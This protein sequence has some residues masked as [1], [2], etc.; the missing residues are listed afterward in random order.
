MV[1]VWKGRITDRILSIFYLLGLSLI[2]CLCLTLSFFSFKT[3]RRLNLPEFSVKAFTELLF[4]P[5]IFFVFN[6]LF[7]LICGW[8]WFA[9]FKHIPKKV[10]IDSDN[11]LLI[12][13]KQNRSLRYNLDRIRFYKRE[14]KFYYLIEIHAS[15]DFLRQGETEKLATCII[16]PNFG[17]SWKKRKMEEITSELINQGVKEIPLR[18]Y[19]PIYEYFNT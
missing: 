13:Q 5:V 10:I 3:R 8:F 15:F 7:I 18:P 12:I 19:T 17:F 16:T 9:C 14:S 4:S 6:G 11:K 2:F 1:K